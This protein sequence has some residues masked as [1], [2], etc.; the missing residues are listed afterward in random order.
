M[1][2]LAEVFGAFLR[3]GLTSFG[4]PVAH[5]GYFRD[6]FV[7][8]RRWLCD[9]DY[10][11]LVALCQFLPGPSSSQVGFALGLMR[12]GWIGALAA[13]VA[14]TLP[15]ALIMLVVALGAGLTGLSGVIAALKLVAVAVVA[16]AVLGMARTLCPDAPRATIA[17]GAV[18]ALALLA[19]PWAMVA[20]ILA[21]GLIGALLRLDT[22]AGQG[23]LQIPV[24]KPVASGALALFLLGL[25]ALP[26]LADQSAGFALADSM[27]RA[28]AL[29]FG[30]GHVVL[31]LLQTEL[32]ASGQVSDSTFLAGYAA[33]Q[34]IPGPLFTF[35]TYLG[36]MNGLAGALIATMAIFAPGFLLLV[37]VLPFWQAVR[38][39]HAMRAAMAGANAAVVGILG[40]ALYDPVFTSAVS[41]LGQF[42][43]AL[44]C[45][46]AL[47]VWRVP[48]WAVVLGAALAGAVGLA[49]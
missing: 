9:S 36:G 47:Q 1:S 8:R 32:V 40:A 20:I 25:V 28:G 45:F 39:V 33:A 3:L 44:A 19:G 17:V 42:A 18:A 27:F 26:L 4:G 6:E 23:Q 16:H 38:R 14:F 21:G 11:E 49:A 15:S 31:P 41:H 22:G 43:F 12:A 35:G 29:V 34:A 30:G 7:T 24:A 13:F 5:I 37:G 10:A 48:V 2:R 46:T